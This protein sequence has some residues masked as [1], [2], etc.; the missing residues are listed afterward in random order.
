MTTVTKLEKNIIRYE[1]AIEKSIDLI[2]EWQSIV[3]E[4]NEKIS[5]EKENLDLNK[6]GLMEL[7]TTLTTILSLE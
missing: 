5:K 6:E 4:L 3:Y 7:Q 1:Q 2:L